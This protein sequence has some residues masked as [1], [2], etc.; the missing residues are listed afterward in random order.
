MKL[1]VTQFDV[2]LLLPPCHLHITEHSA[3]ALLNFTEHIAHSCKNCRLDYT[4][5]LHLYSTR[6]DI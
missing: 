6:E 3:Y 4:L 1:H 5:T 2:T